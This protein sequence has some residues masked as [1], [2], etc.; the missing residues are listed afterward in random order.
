MSEKMRSCS[1]VDLLVLARRFDQSA[2]AEIYDLY[3]NRIYYY[4]LRLLGDADLAE[5]CAAE[6][7]DRLL[8]VLRAGVGPETH[9]QA[10]LY[11]TAHNWIVDHFRRTTPQSLDESVDL[12]PG[13]GDP[14]AEAE[15]RMT[16]QKVRWA[17]RMLTNEQ[18]Q[19]ITLR[20]LEGWELNEI[21]ECMHKPIGAVKA[22][23]HRAVA[24]L[25]KMLL[26]KDGTE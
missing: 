8:Q 3:S 1:E 6:T 10:Y 18:R 22:L 9:L 13:D 20:F 16:Q 23:Q 19:V 4:A 26:E 11:R 24:A 21:A 2:L 7:F 12:M 17:L 25:Q 15:L 14:A 5:D